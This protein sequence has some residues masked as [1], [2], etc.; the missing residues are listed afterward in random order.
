MSKKLLNRRQWLRPLSS[1]GP[2]STIICRVTIDTYDGEYC[3]SG[4][5]SFRDCTT[6]VTFD[7]DAD[8]RR[9]AMKHIVMIEKVIDE[10]VLLRDT[11]VDG[12]NICIDKGW[13]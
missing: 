8:D 9:H 13:S 5:L 10:L 3:L 1:W 2:E 4:R 7:F 11:Y 6:T 12:T